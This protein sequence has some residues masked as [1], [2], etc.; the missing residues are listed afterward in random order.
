MAGKSNM[1]DVSLATTDDVIF[2]NPIKRCAS[3]VQHAHLKLAVLGRVVSF[4]GTLFS[5]ECLLVFIILLICYVLHLFPERGS[6][7]KAIYLHFANR[8]FDHK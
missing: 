6:H 4:S 8:Y 2:V 7:F 1:S 5:L 3:N